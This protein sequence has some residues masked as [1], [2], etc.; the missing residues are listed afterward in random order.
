MN[1]GHILNALGILYIIKVMKLTIV[2]KT[3]QRD[4]AALMGVLVMV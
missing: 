3:T 1:S 2:P 4:D